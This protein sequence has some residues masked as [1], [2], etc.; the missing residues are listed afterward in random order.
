VRLVLEDIHYA[1]GARPYLSGISLTFTAGLNTLLGPTGAGK[2]SLLRLIAGLE[3][4]SQGRMLLDGRDITRQGVKERPVA[5]VY[6]QFVNY[7][8]FTVY[9]NIASPLR[10]GK[11]RLGQSEIDRRVRDAARRMHIEHLLDRL[12]GE[13][14]GGQQQRTAIARAL[15]K[16]AAILLLDEPLVNLDYKLR[17]ELRGELR[18]LFETSGTIVIYTTTEPQEALLLGGQVALLDEGWMVQTGPTLEVYRNPATTRAGEIFSDP[19]MN[20]ME[21][22]LDGGELALGPALRATLPAYAA[23]LMPGRYV[24]GVRANH[25]A[26]APWTDSIALEAEV[27]LAEIGGSQTYLHLR[28][29]PL[30][31]VAEVSGVHSYALGA[32][33]PVFFDRTRLYLFDEAR[34]LAGAPR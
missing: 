3:Q 34:Q 15:V 28:H 12:P 29:G 17:E 11:Q 21:C 30:Q 23:D 26:T 6:Q 16:Q 18:A 10:Q 24:L 22:S 13:L 8:A 9:E 27:E 33:V 19:P 4:P 14:S 20:L 31:F 5:M 7:P 1:V 32:R 2:T 25:I